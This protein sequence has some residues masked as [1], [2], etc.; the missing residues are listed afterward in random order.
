MTII[1]D[2]LKRRNLLSHQLVSKYQIAAQQYRLSKD[3]NIFVFAQ[4]RID[5]IKKQ[6]SE[7]SEDKKKSGGGGGP[8][9]DPDNE[10][11]GVL[12]YFTAAI[13][14]IFT[15]EEGHLIDTPENRKLL[16][17]MALKAKNYVGQTIVQQTG[18]IKLWYGKILPDGRQL[19]VWTKDGLIRDGG[20]NKIPRPFDPDTGFC[21]NPFK[22]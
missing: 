20:I 22:N 10:P 13:T 6:F 9:Q 18:T 19:W 12:G 2:L 5:D 21:L 8:E 14:H 7:E 17:D 4:K 15:N 1:E 3:K 16:L 11:S